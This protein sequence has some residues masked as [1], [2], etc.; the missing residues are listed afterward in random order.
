MKWIELNFR[1]N[2]LP[3]PDKGNRYLVV[4][5][6]DHIVEAIYEGENEWLFRDPENK[7]RKPL[8]YTPFPTFY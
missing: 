7:D 2:D 1:K 3:L 6:H 8:Y 4:I 5:G